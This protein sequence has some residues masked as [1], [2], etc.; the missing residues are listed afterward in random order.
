METKNKPFADFSMPELTYMNQPQVKDYLKNP[1]RIKFDKQPKGVALSQQRAEVFK[2]RRYIKGKPFHDTDFKLAAQK[3]R[4][5]TRQEDK[6][7]FVLTTH[8]GPKRTVPISHFVWKKVKESV[9]EHLADLE[10][11]LQEHL[12]ILQ[13]ES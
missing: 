1:R 5:K 12:I 13:N 2:V 10:C 11:K 3:A 9:Q 7:S 6:S 8:T 4:G